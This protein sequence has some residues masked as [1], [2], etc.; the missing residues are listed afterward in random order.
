M[1]ALRTLYIQ[2][3]ET[4]EPD[5]L[6]TVK[7]V[8]RNAL[9]IELRERSLS[10]ITVYLVDQRWKPFWHRVPVCELIDLASDLDVLVETVEKPVEVTRPKRDGRR[11]DPEKIR[12]MM[13]ARAAGHTMAMIAETF[14]T[15]KQNVSILLKRALLDQEP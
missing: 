6:D 4:A 5:E 8:W 11:S 3:I 10:A 2:D 13:A 14:G 1:T 9:I 7:S 12:A 15:S